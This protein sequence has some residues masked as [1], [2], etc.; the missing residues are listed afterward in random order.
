[1]IILETILIMAMVPI[2]VISTFAIYAIFSDS[3]PATQAAVISVMYY[4]FLSA[5]LVG[6]YIVTAPASPKPR[7]RRT[8]FISFLKI[9]LIPTLVVACGALYEYAPYETSFDFGPITQDVIKHLFLYTGLATAYIGSWVYMGFRVTKKQYNSALHIVKSILK[10]SILP[11]FATTCIAIYALFPLK[12]V[13]SYKALGV[14]AFYTFIVVAYIVAYRHYDP[15]K[16]RAR[17]PE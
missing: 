17:R 12:D 3:D 10:I 7:T 14:V 4:S 9:L 5:I 16:C 1:M 8:I 11:I 13:H 15:K 2:T 6:I